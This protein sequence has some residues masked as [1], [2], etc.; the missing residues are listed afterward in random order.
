MERQKCILTKWIRWQI[1]KKTR[2]FV[3]WSQTCSSPLQNCW[4]RVSNQWLIQ[5]LTIWLEGNGFEMVCPFRLW[6]FELAKN[7][8]YCQLVIRPSLSQPFTTDQSARSIGFD[9]QS[10]CSIGVPNYQGSVIT[11]RN[12][13]S[14]KT[15]LWLRQ[16]RL[17]FVPKMS[18]L[19]LF[20]LISPLCPQTVKRIFGEL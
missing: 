10:A 8:I 7:I 15:P 17:S 5:P 9:R 12:S 4:K 18:H 19:F 14:F 2:A 11:R 13:V 6:I 1:R 3:K 20:S 16:L